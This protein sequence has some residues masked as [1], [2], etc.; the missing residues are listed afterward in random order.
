MAIYTILLLSVALLCFV[1][2]VFSFKPDVLGVPPAVGKIITF[3]GGQSKKYCGISGTKE[4]QCNLHGP[5]DAARF[6]VED[7]GDGTHALKSMTTGQYCHDQGDKIVCHSDKVNRHEKFH[8]ID[9]GKSFALTGPKSGTKRHYCADE[10]QRIR[11]NRPKPGPWETFTIRSSSQLPP[12]S[13]PSGND[14]SDAETLD[15]DSSSPSS[16]GTQTKAMSATAP[17]NQSLWQLIK[18]FIASFLKT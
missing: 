4:I 7:L 17:S 3:T 8:W 10:V 1:A 14:P 13:F 16:A 18:D 2:L 9:M 15:S 5:S 12:D 6:V 11:C